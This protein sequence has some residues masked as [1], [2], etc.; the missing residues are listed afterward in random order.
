MGRLQV[1][2]GRGGADGTPVVAT[3]PGEGGWRPE[4]MTHASSPFRAAGGTV[5]PGNPRSVRRETESPGERSPGATGS[6]DG[7]EPFCRLGATFCL[8]SPAEEAA[9]PG[10][11]RPLEAGVS[12]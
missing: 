2:L 1:R 8:P 10:L 5:L 9:R 6:L 12:A 11:G 7:W 4:G 3:L